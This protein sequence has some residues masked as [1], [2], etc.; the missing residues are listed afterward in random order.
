MTRRKYDPFQP[1]E[2]FNELAGFRKEPRP[3]DHP[4]IKAQMKFIKEEVRELFGAVDEGN[5]TETLDGAADTIVTVVGLLHRLGF[6]AKE[7]MKIVN[8]SNLSKFTEDQTVVSDTIKTYNG[9]R[10]Y[11]NI[12]FEEVGGR[13]IIYGEVGDGAK[14]ILKSSEFIEPDFRKIIDDCGQTDM[15][16]ENQ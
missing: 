12:H 15:F 2:E 3:L 4:E 1:I 5:L 10:R 16:G 7:V 11:S 14:K 6:D 9:D 8:D 13:Y